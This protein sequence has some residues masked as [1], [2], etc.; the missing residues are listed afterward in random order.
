MQPFLLIDFNFTNIWNVLLFHC[1][2]YAFYD[3]VLQCPVKVVEI[4]LNLDFFQPLVLLSLNTHHTTIFKVNL[5]VYYIRDSHSDG[6]DI[7]L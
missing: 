2:L 1:R 4:S 5:L 3:P 6:V 7:D